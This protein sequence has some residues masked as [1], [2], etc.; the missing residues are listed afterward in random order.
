MGLL[1]DLFYQYQS[2]WFGDGTDPGTIALK[3]AVDQLWFSPFIS[4]PQGT[5]YTRWLDEGRA[6]LVAVLRWR[7]W[8]TEYPPVVLS[9]MS[10]WVP[11]TAILY[12]LPQPLQF[13]LFALVLVFWVLILSLSAGKR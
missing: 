10:V 6:G 2:R 1:V 4:V 11:A 13:P 3:V 7:F 8:I 5:L 9:C 12:C